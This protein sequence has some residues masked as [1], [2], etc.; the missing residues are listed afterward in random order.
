MRTVPPA[1]TK[2]TKPMPEA[3]ARIAIGLNHGSPGAPSTHGARALANN[4]SADAESE[5]PM[6]T[7][8]AL[9]GPALARTAKATENAEE[10]QS[11]SA[12]FQFSCAMPQ[13]AA[14]MAE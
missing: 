8:N 1:E 4:A 5:I 6:R 13:T 9:A 2:P 14:R 10:T 12:V 11:G 3:A 7:E